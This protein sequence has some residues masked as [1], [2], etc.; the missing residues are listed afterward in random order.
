MEELNLDPGVDTLARWMAHYIAEQIVVA[1]QSTGVKKQ[2][3]EERCFEAIL[4]LWTHRSALPR[5]LR[6]FKNFEPI[7]DTLARLKPEHESTFF[8]NN[9]YSESIEVSEKVQKWLDMAKE[10]DEAARVW[11]E[12]IFKQAALNASDDNTSKWL[13]NSIVYKDIDDI[14]IIRSLLGKTGSETDAQRINNFNYEKIKLSIKKL[15]YFSEL[16]E[17]LIKKLHKELENI[18]KGN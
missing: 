16:N 11:M 3:A 15:E 13:E 12:Y 17:Y 5:G 7:L 8:F 9:S 2:E 14:L 1:E 6:P 10:I 18:D 4:K